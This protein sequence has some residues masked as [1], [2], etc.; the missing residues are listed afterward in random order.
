M[1]AGDDKPTGFTTL[2]DAVAPIIS[3]E[4]AKRRTIS[5]TA[6]PTMA[7]ADVTPRPDPI[8]ISPNSGRRILM[9]HV[10][11]TR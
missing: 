8:P 11:A 2:A 3:Y 1:S 9:F 7:R 6:W 10:L 5:E 4:R